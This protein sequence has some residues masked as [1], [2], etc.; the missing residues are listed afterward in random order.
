MGEKIIDSSVNAK[1]SFKS[2]IIKFKEKTINLIR[3]GGHYGDLLIYLGLE[4]LLKSV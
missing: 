1:D 3:P 4:K 2:V